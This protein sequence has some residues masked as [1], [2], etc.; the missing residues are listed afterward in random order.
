MKRGEP[1]G[2]P[3]FLAPQIPEKIPPGA[4]PEG[5]AGNP[6]GISY[7]FVQTSDKTRTRA[8]GLTQK[9]TPRTRACVLLT[10]RAP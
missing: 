9:H 2:S 3:L 5:I 1:L 7:Y 4:C 10:A 8:A 6:G